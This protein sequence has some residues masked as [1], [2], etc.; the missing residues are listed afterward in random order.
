MELHGSV[1][2]CAAGD[3]E[4]GVFW[5]VSVPV[6]PYGTNAEEPVAA[7]PARNRPLASMNRPRVTDT[8]P[9]P[10]AL[11]GVMLSEPVNV[12]GSAGTTGWQF[13]LTLGETKV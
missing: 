8:G 13:A 3:I 9:A 10:A 11:R 12:T 4:P 1:L 7:K 6:L 2:H 5:K